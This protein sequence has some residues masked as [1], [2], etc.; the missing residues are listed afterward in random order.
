MVNTHYVAGGYMTPNLYQDLIMAE[1]I[2]LQT[3]KFCSGFKERQFN[4]VTSH[5]PTSGR[6]LFCVHWLLTNWYIFLL[7]YVI[8]SIPFSMQSFGH[9]QVCWR[10]LFSHIEISFYLYIFALFQIYFCYKS[11]FIP[12]C[13][14]DLPLFASY[15]TSIYYHTLHVI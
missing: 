9:V 8:E 2:Q 15:R 14:Q 11:I 13:G 4:F 10:K 7:S 3:C 5:M 6:V 12:Q 1:G